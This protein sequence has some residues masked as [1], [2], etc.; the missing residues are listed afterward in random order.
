MVVIGQWAHHSILFQGH[1]E[2]IQLLIDK[3]AGT[4]VAGEDGC[5]P[6]WIAAQEGNVGVV[7]ALLARPETDVNKARN[8]G[9]TPLLQAGRGTE[10]AMSD[11]TLLLGL[12]CRQT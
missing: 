10:R 4:N 7:E 1:E 9:A 5:T 8:T 11:E 3:G 6:L 2:V 12:F